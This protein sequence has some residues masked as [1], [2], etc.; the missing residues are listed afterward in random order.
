MSLTKMTMTNLTTLKKNFEKSC[1]KIRRAHFQC[2]I[3]APDL[4]VKAPQTVVRLSS[5]GSKRDFFRHAKRDIAVHIGV[6]I[7]AEIPAKS[8][9]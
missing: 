6:L 9:K 2:R 1:S 5:E 3:F 8:E 4:K 7:H